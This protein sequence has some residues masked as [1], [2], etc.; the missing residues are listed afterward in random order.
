[1]AGPRSLEETEPTTHNKPPD[2]ITRVEIKADGS[3][4]LEESKTN[5][6]DLWFRTQSQPQICY[7]RSSTAETDQESINAALS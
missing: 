4:L 6:C 5:Q 2:F 1:M 3:H 7:L